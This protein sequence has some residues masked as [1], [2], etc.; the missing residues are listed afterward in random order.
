MSSD[1]TKLPSS[2]GI[3]MSA[4]PAT[5]TTILD[6]SPPRGNLTRQ[7]SLPVT[8]PKSTTTN[9]GTTNSTTTASTT[10]ATTTTTTPTPS[11]KKIPKSPR[12]VPRAS[13]DDD[14]FFEDEESSD[15]ISLPV[16]TPTSPAQAAQHQHHQQQQQQQQ[17][18][19]VDLTIDPRLYDLNFDAMG[20]LWK[21]LLPDTQ[22]L[23]WIPETLKIRELQLSEISGQ[24]SR[25]VMDNYDSFV[26][27]NQGIQKLVQELKQSKELCKNSRYSV[28][29]AK[30]QLANGGLFVIALYER[31]ERY[32]N[33]VKHLQN[34]KK[35]LNM[36]KQVQEKVKLG[37]FGK[38]IAICQECSQLMQEYSRFES[39]KK[40][41][42][43]SDYNALKKKLDNA[44]GQTCKFPFS[45]EFYQKTINALKLIRKSSRVVKRLNYHF[46]NWIS[47]TCTNTVMSHVFMDPD[48]IQLAEEIKKLKLEHLCKKVSEVNFVGCLRMI[49][50]QMIDILF[51]HYDMTEWHAPDS[52]TAGGSSFYKEIREGLLQFKG[53]MWELMQKT[54]SHLC[55]PSRLCSFKLENFLD[56]TDSLST[57]SDIGEDFCGDPAHKLRGVIRQLGKAYFYDFHSQRMED[58]RQMLENEM[59]SKCPVQPRFSVTDIREV[60][61]IMEDRIS[62]T[63]STTTDDSKKGIFL[64]LR[65]I[66]G[67]PFTKDRFTGSNLSF[68]NNNINNSST[69][70]KIRKKSSK[71]VYNIDDDDPDLSVSSID[72]FDGR[73]VTKPNK[74]LQ[75]PEEEVIGVV[76]TDTGPLITTT[77]IALLR[78]IGKYMGLMKV[79]NP[80]AGDVCIGLMQIIH[81]YTYAIYTFFGPPSITVSGMR[82]SN[83]MKKWISDVGPRVTVK[84]SDPNKP[85]VRYIPGIKLNDQVQIS[86]TSMYGLMQRCI[87]AESLIFVHQAMNTIKSSL[88]KLLPKTHSTTLAQFYESAVKVLPEVRAL[89]YKDL[90]HKLV[91]GENLIKLVSEVNW[92][93][94]GLSMTH[95]PYVDQISTLLEGLKRRLA[96]LQKIL[97]Q[98]VPFVIMRITWAAIISHI[99]DCL[100][101]GYATTSCSNEGRALMGIDFQNIQQ[102]C[103]K[104]SEIR[105]CPHV[106]FV[107]G[108]IKAFYHRD[109]EMEQWVREHPEY[110]TKQLMALVQGGP[111]K[112]S[113]KQECLKYLT[114][115]LKS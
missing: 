96:G 26:S 49:L 59:W 109:S 47:V 77:T 69:A 87:S 44:L 36:R 68:I 61:V 2:P 40:L 94:K 73:Q 108:Y 48:N 75:Q 52:D 93:T 50:E 70:D 90:C 84:F 18:K 80:T 66:S 54:L 10:I 95:S 74:L 53:T 103:E 86:S 89:I 25:R 41:D 32:L 3:T 76:E 42:I 51:A 16:S 57:F 88:Q 62:T 113:V 23:K 34:I 85:P 56:I 29:E 19:E 28:N 112:A 100:V 65:K 4:L 92:N 82:V 43:N 79:L 30:T 78:F 55:S 64:N 67:N 6:G 1:N 22:L 9:N 115:Q 17:L 107:E 35:I 91:P 11:P 71:F 72:E 101:E 81:L 21:N 60:S 63:S 38:A 33:M 20:D 114:S 105:P 98:P 102:V 97:L 8:Q 27:T 111:W 39:L 46:L 83:A 104:V 15:S 7:L 110:T 99:F 58:L 31:K 13:R 5:T 106:S 14:D 12:G 24:L 37:E 45:A